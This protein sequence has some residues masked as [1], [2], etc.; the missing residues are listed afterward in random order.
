MKKIYELP[1]IGIVY[2]EEEV[3][4]TSGK[5]DIGEWQPEWD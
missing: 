4:R 2:M 1:Q 5:E 3:V